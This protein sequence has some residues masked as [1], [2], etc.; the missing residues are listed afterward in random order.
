[1]SRSPSL[2]FRRIRS[3]SEFPCFGI[4]DGNFPAVRLGDLGD[5]SEAE[6][7]SVTGRR[8]SPLEYGI[9]LVRWDPFAVIFDA[10]PAT[11]VSVERS[12][13]DGD[14]RPTVSVCVLEYPS[15][16]QAAG[17]T[18]RKDPISRSTTIT[19][20]LLYWKSCDKALQETNPWPRTYSPKGRSEDHHD[21]GHRSFFS[22]GTDVFCT[23]NTRCG[24]QY[25]RT[26]S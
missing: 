11:V 4:T 14:G 16:L 20:S 1:M 7:S 2:E 6:T 26:L 17:L 21:P 8:M 24:V 12:D 3:R 19:A 9:S 25:T 10:E 18:P 5:D 15:R 22:V 23:Y 13:T